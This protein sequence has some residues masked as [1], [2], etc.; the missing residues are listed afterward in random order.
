[1]YRYRTLGALMMASFALTGCAT[2]NHTLRDT[3]IGA[4]VGAAG[5]AVVGA[6][7]PGISVGEGA[8][9]GALAGAVIGAIKSDGR[10]YYWDN[11]GDC[12]YVKNDQRVYVA[13]SNCKD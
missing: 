5:G 12:F 2:D 9:V 7:V 10:R 4:G 6:V 1:M 3:A 11:R 13:R 8:A